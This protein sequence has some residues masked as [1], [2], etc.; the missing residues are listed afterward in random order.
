MFNSW[1]HGYAERVYSIIET[2]QD[3]KIKKFK[4]KNT[5]EN[6][7]CSMVKVSLEGNVPGTQPAENIYDV[8]NALSWVSSHQNSLPKQYKMMSQVPTMLKKLESSLG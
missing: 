3:I 6:K 8:A 4:D 5:E 7:D 2:G 1:N